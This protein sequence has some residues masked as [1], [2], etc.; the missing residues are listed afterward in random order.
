[1]I[2]YYCRNKIEDK[3]LITVAIV[4]VVGIVIQ[5][6][7]C[8]VS[9]NLDDKSKFMI[10]SH[11]ILSVYHSN[12]F[13]FFN[14]DAVGNA[15]KSGMKF[16]NTYWTPAGDGAWDQNIMHWHESGQYYDTYLNYRKLTKDGAYDS[17]VAGNIYIASFKSEGDFLGGSA[18][19]LQ[20]TLYGK[21]ND[22]I[23][24]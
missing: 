4:A 9:L 10:I 1:M 19:V 7:S 5:P 8:A 24:W 3:F 21:W 20:E 13:N 2:S 12:D 11:E 22:D 6:A 15:L 16:M 23:A 14:T 17:F 18:R